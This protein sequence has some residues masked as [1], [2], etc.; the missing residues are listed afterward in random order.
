MKCILF[1]ILMSIAATAYPENL[2]VLEVNHG[3]VKADGLKL[4]KGTVFDSKSKILWSDDKQI[5]KVI[6]M[7]SHKI[8]IYA[9]QTF[10]VG[11]IATIDEMLFQKQMLSSRDGI[12]MNVYDFYSFFN[13][14]I[15]LL[16]AFSVETGYTYDKKHFLFL[17]YEY[18]NETINKQLSCTGHT[19]QFNDSIFYVDGTLIDS[20]QITAKLYYYNVEEQQTTLLAD[21][22]TIHVSPRQ[23]VT[24]FLESYS[25]ETFSIE[26]LS[27]LATDFC[28]IKFPHLTFIS[29]DITSF[30]Q[31]WK[32]INHK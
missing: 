6:G 1:V 9:A 14:D 21:K 4:K 24:R 20:P 19:V 10:K 5:I 15:A 18:R 31:E 25:N 27:E 29:S 11:H 7:D 12:L 22:F 2:K 17:Q 16:N 30:L 23:Q 26:E 32:Y 13:R 8:Y 3:T 28:R